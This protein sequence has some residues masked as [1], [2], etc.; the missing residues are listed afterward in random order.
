MKILFVCTGN[1]CRSPMAEIIFYNLCQRNG[2][3]EVIVQG[4]GT[5]ATAGELMTREARQALELCG[6]FVGDDARASTQ[7]ADNMFA[8]YD[9]IVCMTRRHVL[10]ID[11]DKKHRHVYT[12]DSV[13]GCGDIP[14]PWMYPIETYIEVCKQLQNALEKLYNHIFAEKEKKNG[15][16]NTRKR[17][18][19]I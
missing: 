4:A 11:Y 14:D 10:T 6:E 16:I 1:I 13:A 17:S 19:R 9:H 12:L 18:R 3:K 15:K 7:W 2:R 5:A 8:I